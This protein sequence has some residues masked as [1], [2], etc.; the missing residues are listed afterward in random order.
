MAGIFAF[1]EA[2]DGEVRKSAHEVMTAARDVA[3][4]LG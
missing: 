2:R 1:A 4:A 3:D